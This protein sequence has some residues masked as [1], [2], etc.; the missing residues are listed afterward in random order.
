MLTLLRVVLCS[1]NSENPLVCEPG[2]NVVLVAFLKK[3]FSICSNWRQEESGLN[4]PVRRHLECR[5]G[6]SFKSDEGKNQ[7]LLWRHEEL[8]MFLEF[9]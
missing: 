8:G 1:G 9:E 3:F 2:S 5:L 6:V 7:E 4:A